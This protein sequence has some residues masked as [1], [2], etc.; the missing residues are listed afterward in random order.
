MPDPIKN[1][2]GDTTLTAVYG[3]ASVEEKTNIRVTN[4]IITPNAK[5][6]ERYD[7]KFVVQA[8]VTENDKKD[9]TKM[10]AIWG[11]SSTK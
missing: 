6:P 9:F 8:F 5:N 2:M 10:G 3:E 4:H 1:P 7:V 11:P